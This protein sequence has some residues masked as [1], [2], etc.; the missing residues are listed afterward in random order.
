MHLEFINQ[1]CAFFE[2][3]SNTTNINTRRVVK[4]VQ[5]DTTSCGIFACFHAVNHFDGN[6]DITCKPLAFRVTM[7]LKLLEHLRK[8]G[9]KPL[10]DYPS[11]E[12]LCE[13]LEMIDVESL[14]KKKARV[15]KENIYGPKKNSISEINQTVTNLMNLDTTDGWV[16]A[17]T[18]IRHWAPTHD[19][20]S[21]NTCFYELLQL[22]DSAKNDVHDHIQVR[23]MWEEAVKNA[24]HL[25][26]LFD[27]TQNTIDITQN[28]NTSFFSPSQKSNK[29]IKFPSA[30]KSR[31]EPVTS[32]SQDRYETPSSKSSSK[33]RNATLSPEGILRRKSSTNASSTSIAG[34]SKSVIPLNANVDTAVV[35][36]KKP[37]NTSGSGSPKSANMNDLI[38]S[39]S[40]SSKPVNMNDLMI[41]LRN[42]QSEMGRLNNA[43]SLLEQ[44]VV[45]M[46]KGKSQGSKNNS[47][48]KQ[49]L[50]SVK[51]FLES[52]HGAL[53][54]KKIH[55]NEDFVNCVVKH[56]SEKDKVPLAEVN[57]ELVKSQLDLNEATINRAAGQC[58]SMMLMGIK[59]K[60]VE[61]FNLLNVAFATSKQRFEKAPMEIMK[62]LLE[63]VDLNELLDG[64]I[65]DDFAQMFFNIFFSGIELREWA[66]GLF[67]SICDELRLPQD[68]ETFSLIIVVCMKSAWNTN[69][70][71]R[72]LQGDVHELLEEWKDEFTLDLS[73]IPPTFTTTQLYTSQLAD[74]NSRFQGKSF[75]DFKNLAA[76]SPT[77]YLIYKCSSSTTCMVSHSD[78]CILAGITITISE[79]AKNTDLEEDQGNERSTS[80]T[81]E[82]RCNHDNQRS[83]LDMAEQSKQDNERSN[84]GEGSSQSSQ[85]IERSSLGMKETSIRDNEGSSNH[86]QN[87]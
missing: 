23:S 27:P 70:K 44:R 13:Y 72:L 25:Q 66:M 59:K 56:I 43:H 41:L 73:A 19:T 64:N 82:E 39:D 58:K 50:P 28:T 14:P 2:I 78:H 15:E 67:L 35:P 40:G 22:L 10:Q 7:A 16:L 71:A 87:Y 8:L 6:K 52:N 37:S 34:S 48:S 42:Q 38:T 3:D 74:V 17:I 86:S 84:M 36:S 33:G 5:S 31:K 21:E 46:E 12:E 77:R 79:E 60:L 45:A 75:Q 81:V 65:E 30:Y 69:P 53:K 29:K 49:Y 63:D 11:N 47:G 85:V 62:L 80:N 18:S 32:S 76:R 20:D 54:I 4:N 51:A 9:K 55:S 57:R 24:M 68:S 61:S 83:S 26:G 1:C